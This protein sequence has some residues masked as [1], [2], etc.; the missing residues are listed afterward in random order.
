MS[1]LVKKK[2]I[3]SA[4]QSRGFNYVNRKSLQQFF[5]EAQRQIFVNILLCCE[6]H[7]T[8]ITETL[9]TR[10]SDVC[11]LLSSYCNL[12]LW[13]LPCL[14]LAN[15]SFLVDEKQINTGAPARE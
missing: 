1:Q 5:L 3:C 8:V 10:A 12:L 14:A 11:T 15:C 2:S 9:S 4:A 6:L 7:L 13:L